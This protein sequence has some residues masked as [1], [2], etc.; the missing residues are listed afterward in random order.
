MGG[1]R[2]GGKEKDGV[3]MIGRILRKSRKMGRK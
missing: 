3:D 1:K 2:E